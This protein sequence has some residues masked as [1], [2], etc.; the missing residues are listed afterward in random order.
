MP[1]ICLGHLTGACKD[2][3]PDEKNKD[4]V[5]YHPVALIVFDVKSATK[6]TEDCGNSP[7]KTERM[8]T[9]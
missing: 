4:C 3:S 8:V 7:R 6:D 2:C 9:Q 1:Q 5:H